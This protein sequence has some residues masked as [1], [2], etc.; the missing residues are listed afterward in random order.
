MAE[1]VIRP[2]ARTRATALLKLGASLVAVG[3]LGLAAHLYSVHVAPLP[4]CDQLPWIRLVAVVG[5]VGLLALA[6]LFYRGGI[7]V[8]RSGQFPAPGTPVIFATKVS[9]GWQARANAATL[10]LFAALSGAALVLWFQ[11]FVFSQFGAYVLGLRGC[12][13]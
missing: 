9:T 8:W 4:I 10:F 11:F 13:A 5:I 12:G 1:H 7:G 3:G 6:V 2:T